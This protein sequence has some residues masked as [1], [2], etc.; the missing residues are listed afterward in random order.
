[1]LRQFDS[2]SGTCFSVAVMM[3]INFLPS[4]GHRFHKTKSPFLTC[5]T[6]GLGGQLLLSSTSVTWLDGRSRCRV[7]L[8]INPTNAFVE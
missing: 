7:D 8:I 1:M 6:A 3:M 4:L 5:K 2:N